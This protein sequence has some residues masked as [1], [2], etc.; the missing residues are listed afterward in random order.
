MKHT[1]GLVL[2]T[3]WLLNATG[4]AGIYLATS[5]WRTNANHTSQSLG[6]NHA[7]LHFF[8]VCWSNTENPI[9][10]EHLFYCSFVCLSLCR[11]DPSLIK[12]QPGLSRSDCWGSFWAAEGINGFHIRRLRK[13]QR[14][15]ASGAAETEK[16]LEEKTCEKQ[17]KTKM[18]HKIV[19]YDY[20]TN[21]RFN[22]TW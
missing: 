8:F 22:N 17:R 12:C 6:A 15:A 7:P 21:K 11:K 9:K 14:L 1:L 3:S 16:Q 10:W 2:L 4:C 18:A 19:F 13:Q 20:S 5:K